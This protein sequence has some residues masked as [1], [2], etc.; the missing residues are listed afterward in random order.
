MLS[1]WAP[2]RPKDLIVRMLVYMHI[3]LGS[4]L[5]QVFSTTFAST[6]VG[7][8]LNNGA[9]GAG[10]LSEADL[11]TGFK[12]FNMCMSLS[13]LFCSAAVSEASGSIFSK[14]A[15]A[16]QLASSCVL[17]SYGSL[18]VQERGCRGQ[19]HVSSRVLRVQGAQ[20]SGTRTAPKALWAATGTSAAQGH[21]LC[22][23]RVG[24]SNTWTP[25]PLVLVFLVPHIFVW[26]SCF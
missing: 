10:S 13:V 8:G 18:A 25:P 11:S 23:Q 24:K 3:A 21:V 6:F 7:V 16:L 4:L 26:G 20:N 14:L 5:D 22:G 19:G 1:L 12:V 15:C 9:F 2:L 17:G